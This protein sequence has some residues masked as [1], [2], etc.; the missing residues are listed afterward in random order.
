MLGI[1]VKERG[2]GI[3]FVGELVGELIMWVRRG[4]F[5]YSMKD[6]FGVYDYEFKWNIWR[7]VCMFFSYDCRWGVDSE[8]GFIRIRILLGKFEE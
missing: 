4:V 1:E 6:F 8:L 5:F 3:N 2:E 7:W